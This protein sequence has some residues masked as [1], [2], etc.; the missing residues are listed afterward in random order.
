MTQ[1]LAKAFL[2]IAIIVFDYVFNIVI[3]EFGHL[4]MGKATGYIMASFRIGP[5]KLFRDNGKLKLQYERVPGTLGQCIMLPPD[6]NEPEKVPALLYHFGGGFFN[7]I[8]ALVALP[9]CFIV[10]T[11][12][13]KVFFAMMFIIAAAM[14]MLNLYP[15]K[16]TVPNDGYNMKLIRKSVADRKAIYRI[17]KI[18]G[19]NELSPGEMPEAYFE[20]DEEGEYSVAMKML[21]AYHCMDKGEFGKAETLFGEAS[22]EK[23]KGMVYYSLESCKEQIFCMILRGASS[24][25]IKEVWDEKTDRYIKAGSAQSASSLRVLYAFDKFIEKNEE[26]AEEEYNTLMKMMKKLAPGDR[27]MESRLMEVTK[28]AV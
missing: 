5:L 11:K 8:T 14:T 15:A 24:E 18:T 13:L 20:Y 28:N 4:C 27:K 19:C 23:E 6:S 10:G 26:K 25:E 3:H 22:A 12:Y 21:C 16:I 17:L 2:I 9:F 1:K 7:A